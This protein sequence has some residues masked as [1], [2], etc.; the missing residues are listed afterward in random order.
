[1]SDRLSRPISGEQAVDIRR[2]VWKDKQLPV[3]RGSRRRPYLMYT[4]HNGL[5]HCWE[6]RLS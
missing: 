2:A 3:T 6:Q 1:M 4:E 5:P